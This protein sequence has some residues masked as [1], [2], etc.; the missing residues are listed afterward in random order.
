MK[1]VTVLVSETEKQLLKIE[2]LTEASLDRI[3]KTVQALST[4]HEKKHLV[5]HIP[6]KTGGKYER[7]AEHLRKIEGSE[8]T[9]TFE[10]ISALLGKALPPSASE[11]RAWWAND[12]THS[13]AK[14]WLTAGWRT[15]DVDLTAGKVVFERTMGRK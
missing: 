15:K 13:Q 12:S 10:E 8:V 11:Y 3:W 1:T 4:P 9:L 7:I 5:P 14:A 6:N 2:F